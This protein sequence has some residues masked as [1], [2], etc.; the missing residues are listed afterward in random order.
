MGRLAFASF[1]AAVGSE[2]NASLLP[3]NL[4]GSTGRA[5][6]ARALQT[7]LQVSTTSSLWANFLP[8]LA[9]VVSS[10]LSSTRGVWDLGLVGSVSC[11]GLWVGCPSLQ[12]GSL[13]CKGCVPLG[14][15]CAQ[16]LLSSFCPPQE[17]LNELNS[18]AIKPQ[19]KP[20]I[21]LFLSVSHNIEEVRL[22][23]LRSQPYFS[24]FHALHSS[25]VRATAVS[26]PS[27][28]PCFLGTEQ[29]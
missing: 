23:I 4:Y 12:R 24:T 3:G 13:A 19:V 16:S 7:R 27:L 29:H 22:S 26:F 21:N 2:L 25:A 9:F 28:L 10:E 6:E 1:P 17:G 14:V 8:L 18:T 20:W 15:S 5:G 11:A